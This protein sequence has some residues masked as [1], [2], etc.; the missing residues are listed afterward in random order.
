MCCLPF[1]LIVFRSYECRYSAR[2]LQVTPPKAA[3]A[4]STSKQSPSAVASSSSTPAP[5]D[6]I[7]LHKIAEDLKIPVK[8]ANT[9]DDPTKYLYTVQILSP[10]LQP[11]SK[12]HDKHKGKDAAKY[13]GMIMEVNSTIMRY[14]V[15][16][17][18][19][20]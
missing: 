14:A 3:A 19:C 13:S 1:V 8:E 9:K 4:P 5:N 16:H 15:Y 7:S 12:S 18:T 6:P 20:R 11:G 17:V 10:E 2:L